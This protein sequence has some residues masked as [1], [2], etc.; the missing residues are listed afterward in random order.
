MRAAHALTGFRSIFWAVCLCWVLE[1]GG[2]PLDPRQGSRMA[3]LPPRAQQPSLLPAWT[4][5]PRSAARGR[6]CSLLPFVLH[7][8]HGLAI[9]AAALGRKNVDE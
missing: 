1:R 2:S 4:E 7:G 3:E 9:A 6:D 8:E 5:S